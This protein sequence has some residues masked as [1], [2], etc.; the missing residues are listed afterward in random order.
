MP[1]K[2]D[3][4][5]EIII[6]PQIMV[7]AGFVEWVRQGTGPLFP[8]LMACK[9]PADAAQKRLNRL[10]KDHTEAGA[11]SWVF[12]ALRHGKI[13]NDRDNK[14]D[15]RLIMKQVGHETGDVH[16]A[17]GRLTP[18]QMREIAAAVPPADIDWSL[19]K[20]IDYEAFSKAKPWRRRKR[21]LAS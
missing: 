6:L 14:V 16:G 15:A 13:D 8:A 18:R 4:S 3:A 5:R 17:Y 21:R 12:H 7:D 9:D 2:T 20:S 1:I 19:L 11:L 10:I